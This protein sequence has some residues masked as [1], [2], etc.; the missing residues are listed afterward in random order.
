MQRKRKH[1]NLLK[2]SLTLLVLFPQ[3]PIS[4]SLPKYHPLKEDRVAIARSKTSPQMS[5][6][7]NYK[8]EGVAD[9][10]GNSDLEGAMKNL[11]AMLEWNLSKYEKAVVYQFM[12]FV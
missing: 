1:N 5:D 11:K 6:N 7:V 4:E 2:L 10:F 8:F 12:G 9:R 3:Y